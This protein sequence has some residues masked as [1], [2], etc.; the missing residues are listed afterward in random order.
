MSAVD[1]RFSGW[2]SPIT[3]E[4]VPDRG[5]GLPHRVGTLGTLFRRTQRSTYSNPESSEPPSVVRA[6]SPVNKNVPLVDHPKWGKWLSS[7]W[8][9]LDIRNDESDFHHSGGCWPCKVTGALQWTGKITSIR[10]PLKSVDTALARPVIILI[11][12]FR[13]DTERD[14]RLKQWFLISWL[15]KSKYFWNDLIEQLFSYNS[16]IISLGIFIILWMYEGSSLIDWKRN[17]FF[18]RFLF[19]RKIYWFLRNF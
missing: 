15:G 14:T 12:R 11:M 9:L 5:P 13:W 3:T 2:E 1:V 16:K 18:Q 10:T 17:F 7:F 8:S 4:H 19:Y 6:L